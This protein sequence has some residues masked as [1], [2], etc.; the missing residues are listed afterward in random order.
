MEERL[1]IKKSLLVAARVLLVAGD[2]GFLSAVLAVL[3]HLTDV[4]VELLK[5]L[6][7]LVNLLRVVPVPLLY[8]LNSV[9]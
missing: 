5:Q 8:T 2:N 1:V 7:Q 3:H 4:V 6:L 9:V